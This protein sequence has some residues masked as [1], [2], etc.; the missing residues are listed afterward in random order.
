[1]SCAVARRLSR[2][3]GD[4]RN[5]PRRTRRTRRLNP[6]S[7]RIFPPVLRVLRGG[8]VIAQTRSWG[9][10]IMKRR[11]A[12]FAEPPRKAFAL[13]AARDRPAAAQTVPPR[14][15]SAA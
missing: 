8:I 13:F 15:V 1:M 11:V 9:N 3:W 2:F 6:E 14:R 12:H 5:P 4:S 7:D 10:L